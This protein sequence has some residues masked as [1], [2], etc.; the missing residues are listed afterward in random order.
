M[1]NRAR[2]DRPRPI[3][4]RRTRT[5]RT[6]GSRPMPSSHFVIPS[7]VDSAPSML[8]LANAR[9]VGAPSTEDQ[10]VSTCEDAQADS[11]WRLHLGDS[12]CMKGVYVFYDV[13]N[14]YNLQLSTRFHKCLFMTKHVCTL[15]PSPPTSFLR[16][17]THTHT[18]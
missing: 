11:T 13:K 6:G 17:K 2:T 14:T 8:H 7:L 3:P 10:D 9:L 1:L 5:R 12:I 4:F 16:H 18:K 15:R